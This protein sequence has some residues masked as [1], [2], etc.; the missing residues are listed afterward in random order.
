MLSW[1]IA[2][3]SCWMLMWVVLAEAMQV[4]VMLV[5]AGEKHEV[6]VQKSC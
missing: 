4:Q 3:R 6:I 2:M 1:L 5:E